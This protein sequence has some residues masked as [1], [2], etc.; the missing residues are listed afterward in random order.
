[1]LT[2]ICNF[3]GGFFFHEVLMLVN[4]VWP[5]QILL[6]EVSVFLEMTGSWVKICVCE[7]LSLEVSEIHFSYH[8][9]VLVLALCKTKSFSNK[10]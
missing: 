8:T 4:N 2:N 7:F 1:M 10:F 3:L 5:N 9:L 6:K